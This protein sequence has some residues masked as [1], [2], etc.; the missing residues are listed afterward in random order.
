MRNI[1]CFL[2]YMTI[3]ID[4][5]ISK[6]ISIK[7]LNCEEEEKILSLLEPHRIKLM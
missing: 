6:C 1:S 4:R 2:I 3:D 7:L 5:N